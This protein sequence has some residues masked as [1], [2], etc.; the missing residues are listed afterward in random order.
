MGS[1]EAPC[2]RPLGRRNR[3]RQR[4]NSKHIP[5]SMRQSDTGYSV[6][7]FFVTMSRTM[8]YEPLEKL[9]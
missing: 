4:V 1:L 9:V 3:S 2:C 5:R 8:A 7:G 6:G